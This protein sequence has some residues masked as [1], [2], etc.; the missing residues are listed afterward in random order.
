MSTDLLKDIF[1]ET[2]NAE[3]WILDRSTL[4]RY[5]ECP[6]KAQCDKDDPQDA[7]ELAK[8]G[9]AVHKIIEESLKE[10]Q[11]NPE[12]P[13][14]DYFEQEIVKC[15]PDLQP[16]I[17]RAARHVLD[18]IKGIQLDRIMGIEEQI[19]YQLPGFIKDRPVKITQ[20]LDLLMVGS[21]KTVLIVRDWKTGYRKLN[22]QQAKDSFQAQHGSFILFKKYPEVETIHWFYEETRWGDQAYARFDRNNTIGIGSVTQ[23]QAI[24]ARIMQSVFLWA[25]DSKVA[26]PDDAKCEWCYWTAKCPHAT[27]RAY[28]I[29]SDP[30]GFV[31]QMTVLSAIVSKMDDDGKE[32][33]KSGKASVLV[34][35]SGMEFGRPKQKFSVTLHQQANGNSKSEEKE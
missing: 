3:P 13:P 28:D 5:A 19:D 33:I 7:G 15:R 26:W 30:K 25:E 12:T 8:S 27:K 10:W 4:E 21:T 18:A 11:Q 32:F 23:E 34:G 1:G 24:E 9:V 29:A 2:P 22:N 6:F 31:D 17:I 16:E 20:A 14:S 35:S